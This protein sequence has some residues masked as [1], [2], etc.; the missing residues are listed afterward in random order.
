MDFGADAAIDRTALIADWFDHCFRGKDFEMKGP[1]RIFRMGGGDGSRQNGM[2]KHGGEWRDVPS[3]PPPG[4]RPVRY[5]LGASGKLSTAPGAGKPTVYVHD[6][7]IPVP[8]IGGRYGRPPCAQDQVC[9]PK[10]I[11]CPDSSPLNRRP[12]LVSFVSAPLEKGVELTGKGT[13]RLWVESDAK[14]TDFVVKLLD[15]YPDGGALLL[16]EG[17]VRTRAAVGSAH[18]EIGRAHV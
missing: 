13:A 2:L 6:P 4:A 11:G 12:D 15:V 17:Q 16:A 14:S 3:W 7:K 18:Q 9:G 10:W 5:Y 1:V 8:T